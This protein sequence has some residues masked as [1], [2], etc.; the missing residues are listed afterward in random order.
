MFDWLAKHVPFSRASATHAWANIVI[1]IG[2]LIEVASDFSDHIATFAADAW[3]DPDLRAQL[4]ALIP[5][6]HVGVVTVAIMLITKMA[7]NRTLSR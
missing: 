6:K 2:T 5:Q 3:G 4:L 1:A 7:R